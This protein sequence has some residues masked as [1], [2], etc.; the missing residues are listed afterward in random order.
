MAVYH[1][2]AESQ[3]QA[4]LAALWRVVEQSDKNYATL[5]EAVNAISSALKDFANDRKLQKN[6]NSYVEEKGEKEYKAV[7]INQEKIV[8]ELC[9]EPP[10]K[11]PVKVEEPVKA[12]PPPPPA[13]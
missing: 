1:S 7:V 9:D 2:G 13:P 4:K 8:N 11:E 3:D 5:N 10:A 6:L 12:E